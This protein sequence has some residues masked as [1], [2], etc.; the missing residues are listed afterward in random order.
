[1]HMVED[2]CGGGCPSALSVTSVHMVEDDG[3]GGAGG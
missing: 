2:D 1:V 3:A